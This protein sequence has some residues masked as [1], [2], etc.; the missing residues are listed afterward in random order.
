MPTISASQLITLTDQKCTFRE[1]LPRASPTIWSGHHLRE[2]MPMA[3]A[4]QYVC[5]YPCSTEN[6]RN[7]TRTLERWSEISR[8]RHE[9]VQAPKVC[10]CHGDRFL[11]LLDITHVGWEGEYTCAEGRS[12]KIVPLLASRVSCLRATIIRDAPAHAK[13][14]AVLRPMSRDAQ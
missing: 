7:R 12:R 3:R 2:P 1:C 9:D 14:T 8:I 6:E 5:L 10:H 13:C 4:S 11:R